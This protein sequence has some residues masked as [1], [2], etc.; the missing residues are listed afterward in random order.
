MLGVV[1]RG[2][3]VVATTLGRVPSTPMA[4]PRHL[5]VVP[6]TPRLRLGTP[7]VWPNTAGVMMSCPEV[8]PST[9]GVVPSTPAEQGTPLTSIESASPPGDI[10][11]FVD[12]YHE[13][14]EVRFM[15]EV[16]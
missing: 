2:S 16:I 4:E 7:T 11:E 12:A 15:F 3:A 6:T 5:A 14:E 13:G 9:Q 1:S 8:V 10:T